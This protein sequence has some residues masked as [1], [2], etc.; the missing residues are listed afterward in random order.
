[1]GENRDPIL[2]KDVSVGN[3]H[4]IKPPICL[5]DMQAAGVEKHINFRVPPF[6]FC[7]FPA[8]DDDAQGIREIH[9][10]WSSVFCWACHIDTSRP[11]FL[12]SFTISPIQ[13]YVKGCCA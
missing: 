10:G 6:E 11:V 7:D 9:G 2:A 5:V 3:E 1:M 4:L 13:S 8:I 12:G